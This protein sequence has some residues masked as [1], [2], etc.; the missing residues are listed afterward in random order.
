MRRKKAAMISCLINRLTLI[1]EMGAG[2]GAGAS[3]GGGPRH[4]DRLPARRGPHVV[5]T[6]HGLRH[7]W[8]RHVGGRL[9]APFPR[10][11]VCAAVA[12]RGD[13]PRAD[14]SGTCPQRATRAE[15]P[16]AGSE[17]DAWAPRG[18]RDSPRASRWGGGA[19]VACTRVEGLIL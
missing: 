14:G 12:W 1:N 6:P 2:A 3:G 19:H 4:G 15:L 18:L 16:R 8:G 7:A 13:R 17:D 9:S 5:R 10:L 11:A